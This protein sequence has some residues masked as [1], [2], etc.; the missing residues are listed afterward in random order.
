MCE[1]YSIDDLSLPKL[2][3]KIGVKFS[4][5]TLG[6]LAKM[7]QQ[8]TLLIDVV[9]TSVKK[10]KCKTLEEIKAEEPDLK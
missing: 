5:T 9:S 6:I 3:N 4:K 8:C 10:W 1:G 2:L 7:K